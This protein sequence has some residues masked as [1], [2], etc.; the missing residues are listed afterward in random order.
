VYH[1]ERAIGARA[2][3]VDNVVGIFDLRGF[4]PRNADFRFVR[5]LMQAF[6]YY[7]PKRAGEILMVDAPWAFMP[8]FELV[9]PLLGKY[10]QLIRF[11]SVA[12]AREYFE[13]GCVP[14]EF[15]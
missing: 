13:P 2:E 4:G 14:A 1:I 15:L 5:F 8:P 11:V 7:Y 6:F 9:K 12:E 10:S 3:G